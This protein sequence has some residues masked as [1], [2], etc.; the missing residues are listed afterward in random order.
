LCTRPG[1]I[2]TTDAT[3]AEELAVRA[4]AAAPQTMLSP[5]H[6]RALGARWRARA[7]LVGL[8]CLHA[9]EPARDEVGVVIERCRFA[10]FLR[11]PSLREEC[12]GPST[13]VVVCAD[14]GELRQAAR[15]LPGTLTASVQRGVADEPLARELLALLT[16][17]AGRLIVDGV[18]TGVE[19]NHAMQ[20][21]GP[22]PAS[23]R[24]DTSSVGG[25]SIL[26]WLRPVCYQNWPQAWLP[27][28]LQDREPIGDSRRIDGQC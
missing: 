20:H 4:R 25:R 17:L 1:L 19:V 15:S 23:T 13:L 22:W 14:A 21:G 27:P 12:F 6:R 26:R 10:T 7:G 9:D 28:V 2:F 8:E 16:P 5:G 24:P 11:E 3:L 18:P